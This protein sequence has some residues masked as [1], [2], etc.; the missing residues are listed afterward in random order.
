MA[1]TGF[2]FS[3]GKRQRVCRSLTDHDSI[4]PN[5]PDGPD[6]KPGVAELRL[7]HALPLGVLV[8]GSLA[9]GINADE[10]HRGGRWCGGIRFTPGRNRRKRKRD[11]A[12]AQVRSPEDRCVRRD[13][14]QRRRQGQLGSPQVAPA[15]PSPYG[16]VMGVRYGQYLASYPVERLLWASDRCPVTIALI[17][18]AISAI[19]RDCFCGGYPAFALTSVRLRKNPCCSSH[20]RA[21]ALSRRSSRITSASTP[22][23]SPPSKS[24]QVPVSSLSL[25]DPLLPQRHSLEERPAGSPRRRSHTAGA[26]EIKSPCGAR[27]SVGCSRVVIQ[28]SLLG[29]VQDRL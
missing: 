3:R 23:P 9:F 11:R 21:P 18:G 13:P 20:A 7:V 8:V 4:A 5:V 2:C 15:H 27:A 17:C 19:L 16:M 12:S 10:L 6:C 22:P 29:E 1:I 25:N 24:F 14:A 28:L 26:I